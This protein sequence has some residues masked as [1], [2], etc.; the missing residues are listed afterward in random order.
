MLEKRLKGQSSCLHWYET[1]VTTSWV[2]RS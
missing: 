2:L 1:L